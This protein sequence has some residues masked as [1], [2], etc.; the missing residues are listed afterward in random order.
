MPSQPRTAVAGL[1]CGAQ[2]ARLP[3]RG[4]AA[5]HPPTPNPG[6]MA[7]TDESGPLF[8][9]TSPAIRLLPAEVQ[10]AVLAEAVA[11]RSE[12]LELL[13]D[14]QSSDRVHVG[15]LRAVCS[16]V[17]RRCSWRNPWRLQRSRPRSPRPLAATEWHRTRLAPVLEQF[18]VT[19]RCVRSCLARGGGRLWPSRRNVALAART[20][21]R[22][23]NGPLPR[24][25]PARRGASWTSGTFP[26]RLWRNGG[27]W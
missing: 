20:P 7:K 8:G 19:G 13:R 22:R 12:I 24:P 4:S 25:A 23:R 16:M 9:T 11:A 3:L 15:K 26:E 2:S 21:L 14:A 5:P 18:T 1:A 6:P 27:R 10:P 17:V